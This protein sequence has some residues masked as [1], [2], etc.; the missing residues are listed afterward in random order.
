MNIEIVEDKK[1]PAKKNDEQQF[2][3]SCTTWFQLVYMRVPLF[4]G[5]AYL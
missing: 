3:S 5:L 4:I 1:L 2:I